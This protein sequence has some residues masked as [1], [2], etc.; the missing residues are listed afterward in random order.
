MAW[1]I[2]V[3]ETI[4]DLVTSFGN[5][6]RKQDEVPRTICRSD[7]TVPKGRHEAGTFIEAG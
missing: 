5:L 1:I 3:A 4:G 7:G 2:D 6:Y